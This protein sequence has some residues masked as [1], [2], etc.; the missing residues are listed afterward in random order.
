LWGGWWNA[1]PCYFHEDL[2]ILKG[3][4]VFYILFHW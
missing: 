4:L 1:L 3:P 2:G